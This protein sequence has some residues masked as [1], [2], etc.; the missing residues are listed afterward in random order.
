MN[1]F[2]RKNVI[3]FPSLSLTSLAWPN[4]CNKLQFKKKKSILKSPIYTN[5]SWCFWPTTLGAM[6]SFMCLCQMSTLKRANMFCH[7]ACLEDN[8]SWVEKCFKATLLVHTT[9]SLV[10]CNHSK[11]WNNTLLPKFPSHFLATSFSPFWYFFV[12]KHN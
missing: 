3:W 8:L 4:H 6:F 2:A 7:L 5:L 9:M 10:L 1:F 12:F 11:F